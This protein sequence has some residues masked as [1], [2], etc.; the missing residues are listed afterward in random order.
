ML[1]FT[2]PALSEHNARQYF[3]NSVSSDSMTNDL[4]EKISGKRELYITKKYDRE[5]TDCDVLLFNTGVHTV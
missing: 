4:V 2:W 3:L 5:L 1:G